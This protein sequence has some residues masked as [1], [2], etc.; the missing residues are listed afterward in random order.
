MFALIVN[1]KEVEIGLVTV[2]R[3]LDKLGDRHCC[4]NVPAKMYSYF[5]WNSLKRCLFIGTRM[6]N[7]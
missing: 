6:V 4:S 5:Y 7:R 1:M 2:D 3:R